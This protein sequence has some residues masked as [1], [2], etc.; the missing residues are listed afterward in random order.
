MGKVG[1]TVSSGYGATHRAPYVQILIEAAD[2]MS[3]MPPAV[4]RELAHS[5]LAAAFAAEGDAF[6]VS[7][8]QDAFGATL[9]QQA[10]ALEMFRAHRKESEAQP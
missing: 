6:L 8:F 1:I 9:E 7:F 10:V 4:A 2:W 5:L 3:Q